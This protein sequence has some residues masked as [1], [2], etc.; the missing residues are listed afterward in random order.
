MLLQ[1]GITALLLASVN[2]FLEIAQLLFREGKCDPH[3]KDNVSASFALLFHLLVTYQ[4]TLILA[5]SFTFSCIVGY[6]WIEM[7]VPR[8]L[9]DLGVPECH[10]FHASDCTIVLS[11]NCL[12]TCSKELVQFTVQ[13]RMDTWSW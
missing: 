2:G 11:I 9:L 4:A 10:T 12:P 3:L 13:C 8:M 1:D 6:V 7:V 5:H